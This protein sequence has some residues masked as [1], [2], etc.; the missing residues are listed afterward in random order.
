MSNGAL[1]H[2]TGWI[3]LSEAEGIRYRVTNRIMVT[4]RGTVTNTN[5]AWAAKATMPEGLRPVSNVYRQLLN[6][7]ANYATW[8]INTQGN[9][10][11]LSNIANVYYQESYIIN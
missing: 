11:Y 4:I 9:I 2:D 7:N 5:G 8:Y 10:Q 3:T 6:N 1:N